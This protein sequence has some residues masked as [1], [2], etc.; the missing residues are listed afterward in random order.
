MKE[1]IG[2]ALLLAA[3]APT[4]ARVTHV[5]HGVILGNVI[6]IDTAT[7][8]AINGRAVVIADGK[9]VAIVSAGSVAASGSARWFEG[10]GK[11]V[12]PGFLDMH[13]HP[14]GSPGETE[15]LDLMLA[16][17][18][19]GFRQMSGDA[20]TLERRQAGPITSTDQ[21]T[22][23]AMPGEI[24][25]RANAATPVAAVAEIARQKQQGADFI[26]VIDV[27]PPTF[28]AVLDEAKKQNLTVA[29]HLPASVDVRDASARGMRSIEHLGPQDT[30]L[31]SCSSDE[32][33]LRA[34]VA[35]HA[36]GRPTLGGPTP[37]ALIAR[38][39]ANPMAF[40][41]PATIT[42]LG[43]LV[44]SFDPDK[45]G[46]LADELRKHQTWQVPTLIRLRTMELGDDPAYV[47]DPHLRYVAPATRAL[48][49][50]V[51]QQFTVKTTPEART[52]LSALFALQSRVVKLFD[53]AGV[54]MLAGS[55]LGGSWG[56]AGF[57][58]HQEFDLL[59]SAGLTPLRILQM[60]TR[61]GAAFLGRADM[62]GVAVGKVADL[63][64]LDGDP[65]ANAANLHRIFAV[66]HGGKIFDRAN[67]DA[68]E[69]RVAAGG[70]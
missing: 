66:I 46:V 45:C 16:N 63:V 15:K 38:I 30:L 59:A 22:L 6:V 37:P 3:A 53:A 14:L 17:G 10:R 13:A 18:I 20:A 54:P 27:S 4:A 43:K 28:V 51:A 68:I 19:T 67:L 64:L 65:I 47:G 56:V 69:R 70:R 7:G 5:D 9:I 39:L 48:W 49:S 12:V 44:A 34:D 52:T 57:D 23:L 2:I 55:D 24:L 35:A 32:A 29:G 50:S 42:R 41:D 60:T 21:P 25:T 36:S 11:F 8:R 58:L 40:A 61:D 26:K 1:F 62:G 33:A 31:L